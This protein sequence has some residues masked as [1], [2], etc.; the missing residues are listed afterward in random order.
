VRARRKKQ[1]AWCIGACAAALLAWRAACTQWRRLRACLLG[2]VGACVPAIAS[3]F[4]CSCAWLLCNVIC[5]GCALMGKAGS[6][7]CH[8]VRGVRVRWVKLNQ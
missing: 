1:V 7:V 8:M 4:A 3:A 6:I 5:A 2:R